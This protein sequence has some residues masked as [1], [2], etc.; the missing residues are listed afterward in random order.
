MNRHPWFFICPLALLLATVTGCDDKTAAIP[1]PRYVLSATA[2]TESAGG[3][4]LAGTVQ[5]RV[6]SPLSFQ[7]PGRVVSRHVAV[8]DE[9]SAGEVLAELD[10]LSLEFSQQSARASL[11]D[12][13]AKLQNALITA[14]RQRSLAAAQVTSV[15]ELEEAEQNLTAAQ[16]AV[17]EAQARLRKAD[18]QLSYAQLKSHFNGVITSV[19]VE[20]GQTVAAGQTVFQVACLRERDAVVDVPEEELK[21]VS[22]GHKFEIALQMD[23]SIKWTGELREIAPAADTVT[24]LRRVK[25]AINDA[26]P[27]FRLG[28]VV[29]AFPLMTKKAD[30]SVIIPATAV[31]ERQQVHFV[32]V[33]NPS[34]LTVSLRKIQFIPSP[35]VGLVRVLSGLR[36]G[37]QIVTAGV[38]SL[39]PGQKI[40]IERT[41]T[42]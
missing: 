8:G 42:L 11:Q 1:A 35:Q 38:N 22:L 27:A 7:T 15:E 23:P 37:E 36:A 28:T 18:E 24:R 29:T 2:L 21:N 12:A 17:G 34:S 6:T 30:T 5:P 10:P 32:W 14:K 19:S 25:I 39:Q 13:Q 26:P 31:L 9:V 20:T 4:S 33:I 3:M 41:P 40:R 16:A